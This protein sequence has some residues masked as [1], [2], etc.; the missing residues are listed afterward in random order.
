[1]FDVFPLK[2]PPRH[3]HRWKSF[4]L[5]LLV[6]IFLGWAWIRSLS[7]QDT[8]MWC[9]ES[10]HF[11]VIHSA[12]GVEYYEVKL[13]NLKTPITFD[14]MFNVIT[15]RFSRSIQSTPLPRFLMW[16]DFGVPGVATHRGVTFAHWFLFLLFLVPWA[17]F[18]FWRV[19]RMRRLAGSPTKDPA[20]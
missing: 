12:S 9:H 7:C 3:I 18:L 10:G 17:S 6:L 5:G 14:T 20:P 2:V 11:G 16:R 1:M 4:W 15:S 19:R 8:V 13:I